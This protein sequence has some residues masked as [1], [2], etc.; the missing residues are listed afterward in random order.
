M[1]TL[2]VRAFLEH[3]RTLQ[4][5]YNLPPATQLRAA[6]WSFG[7]KPLISSA[8]ARVVPR[9]WSHRR[10]NRVAASTPAWV[11]PDLRLRRAIDDRIEAS[12]SSHNPPHGFYWR[13]SMICLEHALISMEL[14][15]YYELGQHTGVRFRHPYWDVDL[16]ELLMR[17]PPHLLNGNGK[18][19]G[20]VRQ[21]VADRFPEL[22]FERQKKVGATS[23]FNSILMSEGPELWRAA[24]GARTLAELGIVDPHALNASVDQ[25]FQ[26]A[27]PKRLYQVWEVLRLERWVRA[28]C[29]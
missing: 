8:L 28:R 12:L 25:L 18:A 27:D 1:K 6:L 14:E 17:T 29:Q 26:G 24:G 19:K 16:V 10:I 4:R 15:E 2:D 21:A 7:A 23:F 22:G 5:S 9:W 20:L 13:E 3:V 11:A